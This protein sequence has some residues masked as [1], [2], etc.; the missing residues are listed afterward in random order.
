MRGMQTILITGTSSGIG[1][2][3]ARLYLQRGHTVCGVSRRGPGA[4]ADHP[5]FHHVTADLTQFQTVAPA[6]V[7]LAQMAGTLGFDTI[8]ANAGSFG[9]PPRLAHLT[10]ADAF[11]E[12]MALNVGGVKATID[13]CISLPSRPGRIVA[14][15]SISGVRQRAGMLSYATSKAALN[16]LLRVYQ[17][18]NPDIQFLPIGLCNVS[19]PL[20]AVL[21]EAGPELAELC[22]LRERATQPGYF[23]S[24]EERAQDIARVLDHGA[25]LDLAPA[26]FREIRDLLAELQRAH[27]TE[28]HLS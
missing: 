8:F 26:E 3:L 6:L 25:A 12:V 14:S 24:P 18:E 9:P 27:P 28:G 13:A 7:R 4:L 20:S 15:A 21:A 1:H 5:R 22:A 2:A 23:V 16:A 19:T 10:R 17:L 11:M